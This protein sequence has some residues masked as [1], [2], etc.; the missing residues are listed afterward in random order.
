MTG[1]H[2]R[3]T[4]PM[5]TSPRCGARTRDGSPCRAPTAHGKTRCRMHGG[6]LG[7]GAPKGNRNARTHGLFTRDAISERQQLQALLDDAQ[8]LLRK[9][10]Q[11]KQDA[12]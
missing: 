11:P 3:N 10:T 7:S 12:F 8:T 4:V 2:T 1:G 6:A 5:R 9:L